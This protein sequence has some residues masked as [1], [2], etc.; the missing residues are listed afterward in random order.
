MKPHPRLIRLQLLKYLLSRRLFGGSPNFRQTVS[1]KSF[2]VVCLLSIRSL[3]RI[4]SGSP[5]FFLVHTRTYGRIDHRIQRCAIVRFYA[6]MCAF[7]PSNSE[8]FRRVRGSDRQLVDPLLE[9]TGVGFSLPLWGLL[10]A[11][12]NQ[13]ILLPVSAS[14]RS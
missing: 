9:A 12:F 2:M 8:G 13:N 14:T 3:V 6:Q 10:P 4:Q 1:E 11:V 5:F 7:Q